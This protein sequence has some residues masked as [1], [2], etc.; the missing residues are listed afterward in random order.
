MRSVLFALATGL[1]LGVAFPP[2]PLGILS[3]VAFVPLLL[4]WA[5]RAPDLSR[6]KMFG[7]LYL[8]FFVYHGISNWWVSSWQEHADPYLFASGIALWIGH[9]IFLSL[10]FYVLASIRTRT[11]AGVMLWCAP[12]AVG[13]FEWLHGQTDAS[14]PWLTTGYDLTSTVFGQAADVIGVYGLSMLIVGVNVAIVHMAMR[15]GTPQQTRRRRVIAF[16]ALTAVV[17]SWGVYGASRQR[18]YA[19]ETSPQRIAVAAIQPNEDPWDKWA[20]PESQ[21]ARHVRIVDSLRK[22]RIQPDL[23]VWSETAI[24]F[25]IRQPLFDANWQQL[26]RWVDTSGFALLTGY[27]D[28]MVY[29][30]NAAPPSAR[31]SLS[32][33]SKRFDAFNAAMLVQGSDTN[34][35]VHRKSM[36]TP[37]AERLPFA[38]HLTFAMS[39][40]QWG[41]G[42][43]G[44]GK[45]QTRDPL[46]FVTAKG[47]RHRVGAIIC[48]ESIY[49]EVSIDLVRN[50]ADILSVITNDAWFNGTPGPWQHERIA[51]MRAIETRRSI[52]RCANSGITAIIRP[53]GTSVTLEPMREAAL[54]G[55][56][57]SN[58]EI[59]PYV[60]SGNFLPIAGLILALA[61]FVLTRIPALLRKLRFSTTH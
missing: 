27:S 19:V 47:D 57:A 21:V 43:S 29:A 11:S 33:P 42:I 3:F 53:N 39:W 35:S 56:I 59:T 32:D 34:I 16:A 38:D 36:L 52:V 50:G 4:L 1:L 60:R 2:S 15:S 24:P 44:W 30:P 22:S 23:V 54:S 28:I 45:G 51:A 31:V 13:G 14:Y 7:L 40:F 37:F 48:I 17:L 9:P 49:P 10:P 61:A 41:V 5:H 20:S 55:V 26:R 8:C 46:P 58:T 6:W 18:Q 12:F 25:T